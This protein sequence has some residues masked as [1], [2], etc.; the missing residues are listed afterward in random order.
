MTNKGISVISQINYVFLFPKGRVTAVEESNNNN[1]H[2]YIIQKEA[3][4]LR[5]YIYTHTHTCIYIY[6]LIQKIKIWFVIKLI[7][8][9]RK[10]GHC[11]N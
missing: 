1:T 6:I 3:E 8:I 11:L 10:V 9:G 5:H 4:I 7:Q 2:I